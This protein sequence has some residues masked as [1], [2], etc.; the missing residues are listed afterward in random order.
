[1]RRD[2]AAERLKARQREREADYALVGYRPCCFESDDE[3]DVDGY[4]DDDSDLEGYG[5]NSRTPAT[6]TSASSSEPG[7]RIKVLSLNSGVLR[8]VQMSP[9]DTFA[10]IYALMASAEGVQQKDLRLTP[11]DSAVVI[12][13]GDTYHDHGLTI[14]D[15]VECVVVGKVGVWLWF[16]FCQ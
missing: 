10:V 5:I 4:E 2:L 11:R 13:P 8:R 14:C 15:I 3:L 1:M 7:L 6:T 9:K 16:G 12:K